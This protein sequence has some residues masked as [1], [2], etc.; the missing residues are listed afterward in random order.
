[1][2]P[3][4]DKKMAIDLSNVEEF[5]QEEIELLEMFRQ[6]SRPWKDQII[7]LLQVAMATPD[8]AV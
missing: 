1:M 6:L 7:T 5:I 2:L 4:D 8:D 3:G